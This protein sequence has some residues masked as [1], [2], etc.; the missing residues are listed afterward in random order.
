MKKFTYID[1]LRYKSEE[2]RDFNSILELYKILNKKESLDISINSFSKPIMTLNEDVLKYEYLDKNQILQDANQVHDKTYRTILLN[3]KEIV[4]LINDTLCLSNSK[5]EIN[6][7]QIEHYN[8]SF[9]TNAFKTRESDIIYK[10]KDIDA[11]FLIE[12]QS[13]IDYSMPFRLLEYCTLIMQN[14]INRDKIKRKDYKLPV[15]YPIVLYTG[16]KKWNQKKFLEDCQ[17][18][19][20]GCSQKSFTNYTI[21]DVNDYTESELLKKSGLLPKIMLLEKSKNEQNLLDNLEKVV[22]LD[23]SEEQKEMLKSIIYFLFSKV[24]GSQ[25]VEKFIHDLDVKKEEMNM[26]EEI[27]RKSIKNGEKR[28]MEQARM[29]ILTQMIKNGIDDTIIMVSTNITE[30]ELNKLKEKLA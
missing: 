12:H 15:I 17:I 27:L 20:P 14:A 7:N 29:Q 1:Y 5:Y 24:I 8:S 3:K 23:L 25:T 6:E 13:K 16:N 19:L 22:A 26:I 30:E 9:I 11:F 2:K 28:G 21:I 10:M 18:R 4:H